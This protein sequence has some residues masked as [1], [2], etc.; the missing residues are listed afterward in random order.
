MIW[1]FVSEYVLWFFSVDC[2]CHRCWFRALATLI[3]RKLH[4]L[5]ADYIKFSCRRFLTTSLDNNMCISLAIEGIFRSSYI[6]GWSLGI[7]RTAVIIRTE[8]KLQMQEQIYRENCII[9]KYNPTLCL[10]S[11]P[12]NSIHWR[13]AKKISHQIQLVNNIVTGEQW[14]PC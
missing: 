8:E 13:C 3:L 1:V 14:L 10:T 4:N 6:W 2:F 12:W 9:K 5:I 7:L 11:Y